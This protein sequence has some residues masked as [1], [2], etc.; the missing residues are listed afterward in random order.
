MRAKD[1]RDKGAKR[2]R[3]MRSK[4]KEEKATKTHHI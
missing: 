1:T 3:R 2:Y 4:R